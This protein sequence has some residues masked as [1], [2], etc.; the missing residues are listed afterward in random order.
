MTSAN[1]RQPGDIGN[2]EWRNVPDGD[3]WYS[4][5]EVESVQ[6]THLEPRTGWDKAAYSG[7]RLI[8]LFFDVG[9][10]YAFGP[11]TEKK[12]L[13][14][15]VFL[16]TVAGVP[17]MVAASLRHL[18]SL[19]RIQADQGWI[20]TLLDEAENERMHLMVFKE[21][22]NPGLLMRSTVAVSQLI[23][24]NA[25]FG[26]YLI[27]P[28]ACH[29][30]VGFIEEEAVHTYT[31]AIEL[32]RA[33]KLPQF[34]NMSCPQS[35][36]EYWGLD[37]DAKMLD[38]LLAVRADEAHHRDVNHALASIKETDPNPFLPRDLKKTP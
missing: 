20:Q 8:R 25:F 9:S 10:G 30:F 37:K 18:K 12:L 33:G 31:G 23:A 19:R 13:R 28:S 2:E 17:G 14:R 36:I 34:E 38:L 1:E 22:A 3:H 29:R 35:G 6:Q 11:V 7:V 4:K 24:W 16:E 26:F 21:L 32:L 5:V 15:I 27:S